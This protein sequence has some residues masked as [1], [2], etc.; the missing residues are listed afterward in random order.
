[1]SRFINLEFDGES[2]GQS[3]PPKALVKDEVYYFAE[4]RSAFEN[5]EFEPALRHYSKVLEFNPENAA[6]WAGQ[7]RMLIEL[8][9]FREAKVWADKALERFP[10]EAELLAAKAVALGRSGDLQAALAFSD[11]AIERAGRHT[12]CLAGARRRSAGARGAAGGLLFREGAVAGAAGLVHRLAG[13]ADPLL[14]RAIRPGVKLLQQAAGMERRPFPALAGAW[15]VPAGAG[16]DSAARGN[17]LRPGAATQS[18]IARE[19]QQACASPN[20]S[21]S[22]PGWTHEGLVST[23]L[24]ADEPPK[25]RSSSWPPP[26]NL[27][28]PTC[29]WS[30]ACRRPSASTARSS[31]PMKTRSP[32]AT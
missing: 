5:G 26:T 2:E 29:I 6:A 25:L 11:A 22:A 32:R 18:A 8:G 31:L 13:G 10:D 9:E 27:M 1:M 16:T 23:V 17:L 3:Q 4:A 21:G 30:P 7:V 14:L 28:L 19:C 20:C 12:V 15:P 24:L